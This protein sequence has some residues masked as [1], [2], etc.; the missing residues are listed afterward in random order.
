VLIYNESHART[1][2][3]SYAEHFNAH[4]PHQSLD[5]HPPDYDPDVV[6]PLD[7]PIRKRQTASG[8][9]NEYRRAA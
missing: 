3:N 8:L 2:L 1:I 4:R 5:Q 7:R 6:I 9:I